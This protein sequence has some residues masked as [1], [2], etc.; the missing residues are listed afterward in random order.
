[1]SLNRLK[2]SDVTQQPRRPKRR[3]Y[4][5]IKIENRI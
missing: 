3:H 5:T 2:S 1:M 4:I